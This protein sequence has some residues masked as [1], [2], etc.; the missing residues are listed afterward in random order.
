MHRAPLLGGIVLVATLASGAGWLA[1][2]GL[3]LPWR[4]ELTR[5]AYAELLHG[6]LPSLDCGPRVVPG[7]RRRFGCHG[8]ARDSVHGVAVQVV[9]GRVDEIRHVWWR[10]PEEAR[11]LVDSVERSVAARHDPPMRCGTSESADALGSSE[12]RVTWFH[13]RRG[14]LV[15]LRVLS[16][17][18]WWHHGPDGWVVRL[19]ERHE[20]GRCA[21]D[22]GAVPDE[23]A[24]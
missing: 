4:G 10:P 19:S 23:A 13:R 3:P 16:P 6:R 12:R 15:E 17:I 1:A 8:L 18:P 11:A 20:A 5:R 14:I 24:M 2:S 22:G 21:R 7:A 9:R